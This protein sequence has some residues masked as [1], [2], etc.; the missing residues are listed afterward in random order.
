MIFGTC[1][2]P[3]ER[4]KNLGAV[5]EIYGYKLLSLLIHFLRLITGEAEKTFE[6]MHICDFLKEVAERGASAQHPWLRH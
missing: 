5:L 1:L 2:E 3:F 6:I 4:T